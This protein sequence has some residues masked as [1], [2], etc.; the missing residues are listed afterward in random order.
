MVVTAHADPGLQPKYGATM[1][2]LIKPAKLSKGDKLATVT[3]S[4]GGP[5]AVPHRY[6]AGKKQL[7]KEFDVEVIEMKHTLRD[8]DWIYRNPQA[9]ADDLMEAFSDTSIKGIVSTIGGDESVRI[10]PFLDET[11]IKKNPKV[12][13]GYSDTTVAH[14]YC[15]HA[16]LS[17]FYGPSIMAGF[18]ENGGLPDYLKDSVKRTLFSSEA[19][20]EIVPSPEWTWEFLDWSDPK[21]QEI[22]RSMNK[23]KGPVFHQKTGKAKGRLIGGCVEVLEMLKGTRYWP[24][25]K[26][27]DGAILF[28]ELSGENHDDILFERW[29]RNYGSQEILS[30]L[31]GIIMARPYL[32]DISKIEKHDAL[33][34]KI[35]REEL[36]LD[37]LPI[38][39]QMDFGHTDPMFVIP[40]GAMAEIDS[41]AKK[42]SITENS[43]I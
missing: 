35:V 18:G 38:I 13:L 3:L 41:E 25:K 16:G 28:L 34:L 32:D 40:Y 23:N 43:V 42:F 6:H 11:I 7:E 27:W 31:S 1:I 33:L 10:L 2:E 20:G 24:S 37:D 12:F 5:G 8:A 21:N 39:S 30:N 36:G 4:W 26:A 19:I 9:R 29:I 17:S 22:K 15:M 14:F